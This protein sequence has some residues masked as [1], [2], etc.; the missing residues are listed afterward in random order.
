MNIDNRNTHYNAAI[1][2]VP[3]G[4]VVIPTGGVWVGQPCLLAFDD[5]REESLLVNLGTGEV[6]E[7]DLDVP[8]TAYPGATVIVA[9]SWT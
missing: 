1:D 9:G 7:P 6:R 4:T 8:C 2:M 5:K 3:I